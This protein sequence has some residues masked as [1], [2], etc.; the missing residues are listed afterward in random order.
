[1]CYEEKEKRKPPALLLRVFWR[2]DVTPLAA[3]PFPLLSADLSALG[4]RLSRPTVPVDR[5][6]IVTFRAEHSA[7]NATRSP[8]VNIF[9]HFLFLVS[10]GVDC[11]FHLI[12]IRRLTVETERQRSGQKTSNKRSSIIFQFPSQ[13]WKSPRISTLPPPPPTKKPK[14]TT[15]Q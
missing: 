12:L 10:S 5:Q 7:S 15:A 13:L 4:A 14:K 8:R 3:L 1:M 2:G 6:S 11:S 9:W